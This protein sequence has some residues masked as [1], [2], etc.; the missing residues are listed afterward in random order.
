MG[1]SSP[2]GN[3]T[4]TTTN[5]PFNA[6][7]LTQ[8]QNQA[9]NLGTTDPINYFPGQTYAQPDSTYT[10][11]LGSA[12]NLGANAGNATAGLVPGAQAT[13]LNTNS[14]I[15]GGAGL[16]AASPY[17]SS[18]NTIGSGAMLGSNPYLSAEYSAQAQPV[19]NSY[20]TATAPQTSSQMEAAGRYYGAGTGTSGA[21]GNAQS[22]NEQNLGTTLNN[23]ASNLYTSNYENEE[24]LQEQAANSGA[25]NVNNLLNTTE[26]AV[27]NTPTLTQMPTQDL[28]TAVNAGTQTQQLSQNSLNDLISRFYGTEES[29]WTTLQQEAGVVGGAIPG[30]SA[31]TSPYFTN[32]TAQAL[33]SAVGVNS[34][35]GSSGGIGTLM[36]K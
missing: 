12:E 11:A 14:A 25:T 28:Q 35:L 7:Q 23:L 30:T 29:P 2:A 21:Q 5:T 16:A 10:G 6:A 8:V 19:L 4:T 24:N 31:T 20:M 18:L 27:N 34:L 26:N 1:G 32:S 15:A 36:G 3:T 22:V 17:L 13:A 33:G 9:L